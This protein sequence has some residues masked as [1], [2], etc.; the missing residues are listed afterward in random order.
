MS[1]LKSLISNFHT[2]LYG[3]KT[4]KRIIVI[5]SD[6]WGSIRMPNK[7]V[8]NKLLKAGIP[9]DKSTYCKFDSLENEEDVTL[10]FDVLSSVK[11][12]EGYNPILTANFV[13]ANPDF[14]KI[15][16]NNF[17]HY[18]NEPINETYK[19][20]PGHE[21]VLDIIHQGL[22]L[23][24][25][26]PQFHGREHVNVPLWLELLQTNKD[27]K[28]AFDLEMWGLSND[29]FPFMKKSIQATYDSTNLNYTKHSIIQ[30]LELFEQQFG[31]KSR[32]FIANNY[33]W[34]NALNEV[35]NNQGIEHFQTMKYQL[36]PIEGNEKRKMIRRTF[37]SKNNFGQT[38][39]PRNCAFEP[40]VSKHDY[41]STLNQIS[42]AFIYKKPAIISTHRINFVG[43]LNKSKR[44]QNLSE[45]N[46]LLKNIVK[47][48]PDVIFLS[49][50]ELHDNI[51]NHNILNF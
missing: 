16:A 5:E 37:G 23:G 33:I 25:I 3:K 1:K 35:L 39:A 17:Q 34:A 46:C 36:L 38:Y 47:R 44:D 50:D 14:Q 49:S 10:L 41:F 45:L 20:L 30:G 6:D 8:F 13:V 42:S 4:S 43:G 27:F 24:V 9:V 28:L 48:W 19:R 7:Y 51:I 32:T 18:Y 22:N 21:K 40:S 12:R 31:F 2:N 11:N 29:V 15:K 26:R